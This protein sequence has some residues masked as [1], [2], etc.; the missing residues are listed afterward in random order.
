MNFKFIRDYINSLNE[1]YCAD[2]EDSDTISSLSADSNTGQICNEERK[3]ETISR[4]SDYDNSLTELDLPDYMQG[5]TLNEEQISVITSQLRNPDNSITEL[6]L[7]DY[8]LTDENRMALIDAIENNTRLISI[9]SNETR[10]M[11]PTKLYARV[12]SED[13]IDTTTSLTPYI[14]L[15]KLL[16]RNQALPSLKLI[17]EHGKD[18][19]EE[20]ICFDSFYAD[21]D[22]YYK[23]PDLFDNFLEIDTLQVKNQVKSFLSSLPSDM[24]WG[25][26]LYSFGEASITLDRCEPDGPPPSV[27]YSSPPE[28]VPE[29]N[30]HDPEEIPGIIGSEFCH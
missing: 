15:S 8:I 3:S 21:L 11:R 29:Y 28:K 30:I 25:Y 22:F 2:S 14:T 20:S 16:L 18:T 1:G 6:D 10:G 13:E 19:P 23:N 7:S 27:T 9:I 17:C 5:L 12:Y 24:I 4:L 26:D